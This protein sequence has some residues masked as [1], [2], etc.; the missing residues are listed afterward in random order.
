M[1]KRT[2]GLTR[3][4]TTLQDE[5]NGGTGLEFQ[6]T[7]LVQYS[8]LN[9]FN[10]IKIISDVASG[11]LET[12][13]G[14]EELKKD[15]IDGK[16][17][18]VLI[19]NVSRSFRSMV[20]FSRFY[21]FL[22]KHDV[23]LI[24]VSEGIRSSRKEGEMLF[25]IMASIAGYEK[26]L[27]TERMVSGRI[28]KASKGIN[29][30]K[31]PYGYK[32]N[33]KGEVVVD[34]EE[35]KAVRYIFKKLNQL[36]KSVRFSKSKTKRTRHLINLLTENGYT[37]RGKRFSGGNI[38]SIRNNEFYVGVLNYSNITTKH[39]YPTLVSKRLFNS[40]AKG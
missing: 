26:N 29:V 24:S 22:N 32:K 35:S 31:L 19:W 3:I 30:S 4:S 18:V 16:V 15:V 28:T 5:K 36:K 6:K 11:G 25:G 34:D 20:H 2:I 27:I 23:E 39:E 10:L 38:R 21:E 13:D 17:D 37:F 14:V 1:N 9:D 8:E 33:S 7:K 12:R 40:V